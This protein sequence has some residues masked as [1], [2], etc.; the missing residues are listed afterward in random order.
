MVVAKRQRKEKALKNGT[1]ENHRTP[2]W[3]PQVKQTVLLASPIYT[4]Q[5]QDR[6]RQMNKR[7][8]PRQ[9]EESPLGSAW[10][11]TLKVYF[12]LFAE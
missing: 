9:T 7:R 8:K 4:G 3:E 5:A 11:Q 2:E 6:R 12:P 10:P 1:K